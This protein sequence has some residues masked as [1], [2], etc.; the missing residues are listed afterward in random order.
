MYVGKAHK[1]CCP[2]ACY[3]FF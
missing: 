1:S 2:S 3:S